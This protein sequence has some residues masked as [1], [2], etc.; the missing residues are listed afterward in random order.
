MGRFRGGGGA[1][2]EKKGGGITSEAEGSW[3]VRFSSAFPLGSASS[4]K[5]AV[6]PC[7]QKF[8]TWENWC[9]AK[10]WAVGDQGTG[11]VIEGDQPLAGYK[12]PEEAST[13]S[14]HWTRDLLL[15][16]ASRPTE[17]L[18]PLLR[19]VKEVLRSVKKC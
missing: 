5:L 11:G 12:D 8:V 3:K 7:F 9:C 15:P 6:R 16:L 4:L 10:A 1:W 18:Q 13:E 19:S 17:T 2:D 14:W